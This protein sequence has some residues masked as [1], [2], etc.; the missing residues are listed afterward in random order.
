MRWLPH[1]YLYRVTP[2]NCLLM[3]FH[4]PELLLLHPQY[5]LETNSLMMKSTDQK[6][7]LWWMRYVMF[8]P[9]YLWNLKYQHMWLWELFYLIHL[10]WVL[11]FLCQCLFWMVM[12]WWYLQLQYYSQPILWT[13][14]HRLWYQNQIF[15]QH[16]NLHLSL[17]HIWRCRRYSLCRS[18]WSPY[19]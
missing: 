17:I 13:K 19:H 5:F 15:A 12:V 11:V 8:L 18:R 14:F 7:L 10:F 1:Y 6:N 16:H 2:Y 4:L 3:M 9:H